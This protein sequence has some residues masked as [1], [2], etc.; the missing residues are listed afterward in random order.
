MADVREVRVG[1]CGFTMG[2]KAYFARYRV[3]EVQQTFYQ[4]PAEA[5][6][7]GWREQAPPD[8][9]FTLKAWQLITH[10]ITSSTYRRLRRALSDEERAGL[11]SF[12]DTPIVAEGWATTLRCAELLRATAILFQCPA[13]FKPTEENVARMRD[14]FAR[15]AGSTTARLLWEP[16]GPWPDEL[17]RST[18]EELG[19]VH[20]VDPFVNAPLTDD[21]T[22]LR[23]H[24]TSGPRHVYSDHQLARL[25]DLLPREGLTYVMFNNMPRVRDSRRFEA[26][27]RG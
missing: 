20:V 17:V 1:L 6:L 16:R 7:A 4:P 18:C 9:E 15:I 21:P 3:L 12:R 2:A 8:F 25:R 13:S 5:T 27:M 22:Y 26:L 24:G 23:L 14:F 11:G 19:L 10:A